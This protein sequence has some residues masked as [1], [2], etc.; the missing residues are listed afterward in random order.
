MVLGDCSAF[1]SDLC[2]NKKEVILKNFLDVPWVPISVSTALKTQ[3]NIGNFFK[4]LVSWKVGGNLCVQKTPN[5][6]PTKQIQ[7]FIM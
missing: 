4:E 5:P 1:S 7:D 2:I 6:I 3:E